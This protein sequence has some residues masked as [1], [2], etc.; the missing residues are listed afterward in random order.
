MTLLIFIRWTFAMCWLLATAAFA[1]DAPDLILL[2][3]KIVTV[4]D[5]FG[6]AQ[7]IA[8]KGQRIVAVGTNADTR[9]LAG[10]NAKVIALRGRTV[11]PGLND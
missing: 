2:N 10:A 7:A 1:A 5:R 6:I 9:K 4:D 8:I 3:G 11:I